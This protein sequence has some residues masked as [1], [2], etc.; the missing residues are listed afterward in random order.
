MST[1]P[2]RRIAPALAGL[3]TLASLGGLVAAPAHASGDDRVIKRGSCVGGPAVWKL[4]VQ[5][6][7]G[8][9]E[10]E[11][12]VDSN[13]R[14]QV[15]RWTIRHN[16]SLSRSGTATTVGASGSFSIERRLVD[17]AGTDRVVFTAVR[18]S[19]VC[20]GVVNYSPSA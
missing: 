8:R 19:Q 13:R 15:W 5:S 9:L 20:R 7:D 6:D 2:S 4:K 10:V 1:T 3:V 17:L 11:G 18:G 14:G 12:E 16:G